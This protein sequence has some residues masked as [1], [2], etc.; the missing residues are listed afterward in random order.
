V[1]DFLAVLLGDFCN[2]YFFGD[3]FGDVFTGVS[4]SN[5]GIFGFYVVLISRI[6]VGSNFGV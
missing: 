1:G 6:G 2:G 3:T 4:I 5:L